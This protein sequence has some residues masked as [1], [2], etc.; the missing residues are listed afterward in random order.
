MFMI[1]IPLININKLSLY[2]PTI[3]SWFKKMCDTGGSN[4]R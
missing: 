2:S 4:N 1:L 3:L